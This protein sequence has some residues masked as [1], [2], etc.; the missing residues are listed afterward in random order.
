MRFL[1]ALA[2]LKNGHTLLDGSER[3]RKR[4]IAG[5]LEGLS[6]LG[7]RAYSEE[8]S[9]YPP[10]T[11]E[12]Q[13]I[14]GGVAKIRSDESSQF[15][16]AVLMVA[17]YAERDVCLEVIGLLSSR[18]YVDMTLSVMSAFGVEV[19]QREYK[20]FFVKAGQ[21]YLPRTYHIEGDASNASYFFSAAAVTGG[22][23][24]VENF[25]STSVQG[26]SAFLSILEKM[27]CSVTR[28]DGWAEVQ[29][30]RL[31]GT[32]IDMNAM[33]DLVPT[34]A[35]TAAFAAGKTVIKNIGH[36]RFKESDRIRALAER[37][38]QDG[39]PGRRGKRLAEG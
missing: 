15:L 10:V 9:G 13:G 23:V 33:P 37:T 4:P 32:E 26:D 14:K 17:P 16:S 36:L 30:G 20:S 29:G 12:S 38:E 21:R 25:P 27:G 35:V 34:L 19:Q 8:G 28:N 5:L 22:K 18:P 6:A 3:M 31:R 1:C 24:R 11:V 39:H 2:A 7:V